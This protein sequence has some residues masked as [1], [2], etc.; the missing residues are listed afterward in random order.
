[1]SLKD[2]HPNSA[3]NAIEWYKKDSRYVYMQKLNHQRMQIE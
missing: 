3:E 2:G 1:M